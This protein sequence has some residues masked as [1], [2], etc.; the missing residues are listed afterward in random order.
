MLEMNLTYDQYNLTIK[1]LHLL[2]EEK[3]FCCNSKMK[4]DRSQDWY[5]AYK[6]LYCLNNFYYFSEFSLE[7][8]FFSKTSWIC[9]HYPGSYFS[10]FIKYDSIEFIPDLSDI[11][12][13]FKQIEMM[14][15]YS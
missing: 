3:L 8:R 7:V 14:N 1:N 10:D 2:H 6:C 9:S 11:P 13:L 5:K 4:I 12:K 15:F